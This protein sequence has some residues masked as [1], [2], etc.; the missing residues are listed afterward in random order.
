MMAQLSSVGAVAS[1]AGGLGIK[2]P[3]DQQ[4]ALLKSRIVEDAMV[5]RFHLQDLYHSR[6]LSKARQRWEQK[7]KS[8][9]RIEGRTD[10][11]LGDGS[12]SAPGRGYGQRLGGGIPAL[13]RDT[14]HY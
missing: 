9:Q 13:L 12:R 4:I 7:H 2:N 11:S 5:S 8:R 14:R 10:S 3:N 1:A 6:Y